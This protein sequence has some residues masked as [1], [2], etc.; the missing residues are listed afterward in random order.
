[1]KISSKI[2]FAAA[3]ALSGSV[4][5]IETADAMPLTQPSQIGAT[6]PVQDIGWRCGPG[7]HVNPWGRCVPNRPWR[8]WRRW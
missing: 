7:R 3:L 4:A 1:M 6:A 5:A 8:R 2:L